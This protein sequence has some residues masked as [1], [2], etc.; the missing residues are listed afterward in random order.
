[1]KMTL[2]I[3]TLF[4]AAAT[5]APR[6]S[7]GQYAWVPVYSDAAAA[8]AHNSAPDQSGYAT[9]VGEDDL[10][11]FSYKEEDSGCKTGGKGDCDC[12]RCRN[13]S[14]ISRSFVGVEYLQW[15]NKGRSL[16]PLVTGGDPITTPFVN[17]G[18]LPNAPILFGGNT[19]GGDLKA[20]LRL[21]GGL[22]LDDCKTSALVVRAYGTEGD[23]TQFAA[24]SLGNP[25]LAV[26]FVDRSAAFFGQNNALVLAY[27]GNPGSNVI[28]R[29]SV[30]ATASNDILG[31]DVYGRT[32]L[33]QGTDYR[34]DLLGGYQMA[35]IDDDLELNTQ[36]QRLDLAGNPTA[37]TRD[38]FDVEN[39]YHAGTL[40]LMGEFYRGPWT[41]QMMGKL[42]VGNMN[43]RVAISGSN[44]LNGTTTGGGIFAQDQA[45]NGGPTFNIGNYQRNLLVWSPEAS[46]K[47]SYCVTDRLSITVGYTLLYWTRV[48]L[49][50]DQVDVNVNRDVLFNGPFQAGGGASPAFAFR[51]TDFWVQTIDIGLLFNY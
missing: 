14:W 17:A 28:S 27:A 34:L 29:G 39:E 37:T 32:L 40:G 9:Y 23:R 44:T 10:E 48:A 42:G 21:T 38:L 31:G 20:G 8:E 41:I 33:D 4:A 35:R 43:Q 50:G 7:Y 45:G 5:I 22:W 24:N 18:R 3:L 19:V 15:W 26:P 51:D 46:V 11:D 2:T 6:Q 12:P 30:S 36:L 49:A 25:I 47:A 1:M 13:V 16:P